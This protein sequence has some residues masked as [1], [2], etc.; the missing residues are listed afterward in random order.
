MKKPN[1]KNLIAKIKADKKSEPKANPTVGMP[2]QVRV[3]DMRQESIDLGAHGAS[4]YFLGG[5]A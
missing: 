5:P 1:L 4:D 3:R 2:G